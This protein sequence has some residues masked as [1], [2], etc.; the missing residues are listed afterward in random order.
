MADSSNQIGL[1]RSWDIGKQY[2]GDSEWLYRRDKVSCIF[3]LLGTKWVYD[4]GIRSRSWFYWSQERRT[5]RHF[6][7]MF[8]RILL[9]LQRLGIT[10]D[11]KWQKFSFVRYPWR[12]LEW[13]ASCCESRNYSWKCDRSRSSNS[14]ESCDGYSTICF[15]NSCDGAISKQ[16]L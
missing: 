8:I 10:V 14:I 6:F 4:D 7:D 12:R 13:T 15:V 9:V 1:Q 2:K 3:T 11:L 16:A 5:L